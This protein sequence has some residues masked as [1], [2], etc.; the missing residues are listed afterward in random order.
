MLEL[1]GAE[2]DLPAAAAAY[3]QDG[4]ESAERLIGLVNNLLD[5]SRLE[6]GAI[7]VALGSVRLEDVTNSVLDDLDVLR[8]EKG[9]RL[10]VTAHGDMPPVM[11]DAQL[12]RQAIANLASNAIKYT[13]PGGEIT[14]RMSRAGAAVRWSIEDTG[15]GVPE[16]FHPRLFE[17]F[18]RADNALAIETEGTGLGLCL[19]RLILDQFGGRVEC[20]SEEGKGST[21]TL[22]IPIGGEAHE[23][24]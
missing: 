14:I 4:R 1:A 3:V 5:I 18:H 22:T 6:R 24:S 23:R 13:P 2:A 21:F 19:V 17:K 9:H 11:A 12:L 20:Q 10:S 16:S 7:G 8:R 15:I